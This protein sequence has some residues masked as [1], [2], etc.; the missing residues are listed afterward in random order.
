MNEH[1][2]MHGVG[3][4][5]TYNKYSPDNQRKILEKIF[6]SGALLSMRKQGRPSNNGFSGLDYVSL[7]DYEKRKEYNKKRFYNTYYSYIINSLALAFDKE[8]IKVIHPYIVRICSYSLEGYERM[9]QYGEEEDRYSDLPDE[10]QVRDQVSLDSMCGITFPTQ[11]FI[12]QYFFKKKII[13]LDNLKRE[14][15]EIRKLI[16]KYGYN[17]NIYDIHTLQELNDENM[18]RLVLKR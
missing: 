10:V 18:E 9:K 7:C 2:Y 5:P 17:V 8:Q 14:I 3:N 1:V 12:D 13:K 15:E 16:D 4:Y 11:L 6:D